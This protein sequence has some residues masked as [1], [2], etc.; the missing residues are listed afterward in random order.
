MVDM[1]IKVCRIVIVSVNREKAQMA[2][3]RQKGGIFLLSYVYYNEFGFCF[4]NVYIIEFTCGKIQ[5]IFLN[6]LINHL[7]HKSPGQLVATASY[8]FVV[9]KC[10]DRLTTLLHDVAKIYSTF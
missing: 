9:L 4:Y 5:Q 2:P 6:H 10:C 8:N 7:N 3:F 1:C